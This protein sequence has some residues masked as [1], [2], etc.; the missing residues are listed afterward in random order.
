MRAG[1]GDEELAKVFEAAVAAKPA[2]HHMA[3]V[4]GAED[5]PSESRAR[6]MSRIGG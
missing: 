6:R 4:A 5:V 3:E 1:A 2:C